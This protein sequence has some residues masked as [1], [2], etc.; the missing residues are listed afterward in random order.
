MTDASWV[1]RD[2]IQEQAVGW[3][4]RV[5]GGKVWVVGW[6]AVW[7]LEWNALQQWRERTASERRVGRWVGEWW[8]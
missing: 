5:V 6:A 1:K 2:E 4:V 7:H 8:W 3:D